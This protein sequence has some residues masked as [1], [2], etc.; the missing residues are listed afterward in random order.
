MAKGKEVT[1][2]ANTDLAERPSWMED[3]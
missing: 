3:Q 1:V 2:A